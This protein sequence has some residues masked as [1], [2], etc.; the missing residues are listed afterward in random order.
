LPPAKFCDQ[1]QQLLLAENISHMREVVGANPTA[2]T[3]FPQ[4]FRG[5]VGDCGFV[6]SKRQ[7]REA[8]RKPEKLKRDFVGEKWR[9]AIAAGTFCASSMKKNKMRS[10]S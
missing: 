1:F 10:S 3:K 2:T 4:K 7:V 6:V 9:S 8:L 5:K